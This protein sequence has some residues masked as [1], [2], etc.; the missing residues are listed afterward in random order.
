M[1]AFK[2]RAYLKR[3]LTYLSHKKSSALRV[4]YFDRFKNVYLAHHTET[5][6]LRKASAHHSLRL[7]SVSLSALYHYRKHRFIK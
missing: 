4:T 3:V 5:Y 6:K 7:L 2:I 1:K